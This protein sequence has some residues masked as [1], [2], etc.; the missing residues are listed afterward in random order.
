MR[1]ATPLPDSIEELNQ[2][3]FRIKKVVNGPS[4]LVITTLG[5]DSSFGTVRGEYR[6]DGLDEE[7]D[8]AASY[9]VEWAGT[10]SGAKVG[11]VGV[12]IQRTSSL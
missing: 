2:L 12:E 5:F 10:Y 11:S 8:P 7:I 3:S 6:V 4:G 9:F 1:N